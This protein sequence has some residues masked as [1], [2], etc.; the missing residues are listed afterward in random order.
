M[1]NQGAWGLKG[2]REEEEEVSLKEELR[3]K[4]QSGLV[5]LGLIWNSRG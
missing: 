4:A 5:P 1:M 3:L 2:R